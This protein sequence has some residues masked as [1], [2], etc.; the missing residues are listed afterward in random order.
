MH[1]TQRLPA[2]FFYERTKTAEDLM[3]KE[4]EILPC[5]PLH[6]V[7]GHIINLYEEI[8]YHACNEDEKSLIKPV[9]HQSLEDK[10]CKRGVDY[11]ASLIKCVILLQ[12]K[13]DDDLL[14][15]LETM[16]EIQDLMYTSEENRTINKKKFYASIIKHFCI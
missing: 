7:K 13:I 12:N 5:E 16:Y 15:I 10:S 11:R 2:L 9:I 14:N 8:P 3:L 1:G 6:D 4:Y